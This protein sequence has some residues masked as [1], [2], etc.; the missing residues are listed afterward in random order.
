MPQRGFIRVRDGVNPEDL[1]I[2][3]VV[4]CKERGRVRLRAVGSEVCTLFESLRIAQETLGRQLKIKILDIKPNF[5]GP[6][7]ETEIIVEASLDE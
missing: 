5:S 7:R 6:T 2:T 1:A 3:L 4:E